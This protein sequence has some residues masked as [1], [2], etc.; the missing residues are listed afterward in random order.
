ME[1]LTP[2]LGWCI[3]ILVVEG[4]LWFLFS[5]KFKEI[6]L[7]VQGE[8][9]FFHFFTVGRLRLFV[10][11]HTIVLLTCVMIVHLFLWP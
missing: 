9:I 7:P 1:A 8:E 3:F 10:I 4:L 2:L 11:I 6:C 5:R